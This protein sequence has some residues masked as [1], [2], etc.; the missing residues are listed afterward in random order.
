MLDRDRLG[1]CHSVN[2]YELGKH[3]L[4]LVGLEKGL[5]RFPGHPCMLG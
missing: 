4:D 1:L 3:E 5:R 2:I